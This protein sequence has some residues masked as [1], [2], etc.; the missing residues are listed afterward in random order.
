MIAFAR[1]VSQGGTNVLPGALRRYMLGNRKGAEDGNGNCNWTAISRSLAEQ[2]NE[3]T[4]TTEEAETAA[5][6]RAQEPAP[7]LQKQNCWVYGTLNG[8]GALAVCLIRPFRPFRSFRSFPCILLLLRRQ[9]VRVRL[10]RYCASARLA[11]RS[12][13]FTRSRSSATAN[14]MIA[15]MMISWM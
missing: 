3:F 5:G 4:E 10:V 9:W 13:H 12:A 14:T 11:E 6:L 15:P 2:Q 8:A 1:L 7:Q